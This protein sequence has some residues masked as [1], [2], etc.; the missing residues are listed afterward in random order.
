MNEFKAINLLTK[1]CYQMHGIEIRIPVFLS[2]SSANLQS[3]RVDA[4]R[5]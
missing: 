1:G 5:C 2:L 3:N 4:P